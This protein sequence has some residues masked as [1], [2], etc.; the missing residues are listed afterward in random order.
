MKES[1]CRNGAGRLLV[2]VALADCH[3]SLY[4]QH[5][6]AAAW[7]VMAAYRQGD[8][9]D[10]LMARLTSM[11]VDELTAP[12]SKLSSTATCEVRAI[13]VCAATLGKDGCGPW[14]QTCTATD[15]AYPPVLAVTSNA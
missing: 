7:E 14:A 15:E 2:S 10:G 9:P 12:L 3:T 13:G 6:D 8:R 11:I 1:A 5:S 4:A